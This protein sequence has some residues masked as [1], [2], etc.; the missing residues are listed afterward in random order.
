MTTCE[1]RNTAPKGAMCWSAQT[2]IHHIAEVS[3]DSDDVT[4]CDGT[5]ATASGR[6]RERAHAAFSGARPVMHYIRHHSLVDLRVLPFLA[7]PVTP[8]PPLR[9]AMQ[10]EDVIEK[11]A[12][13]L[14]RAAWLQA[15][16]GAVLA[17]EMPS[18][19]SLSP[20]L[21]ET[22]RSAA[23]VA[24]RKLCVQQM[25]FAQMGAS[26]YFPGVDVAEVV[27]V[28]DHALLANGGR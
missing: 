1:E 24:V 5:V 28:F 23:I 18:F 20:Q 15:S 17:A 13:L 4:F 8:R 19:G 25:A 11:M 21:R 12:Q 16:C 14:Q 10:M 26:P 3:C 2:Y 22:F 7:P 6:V 9:L 27:R